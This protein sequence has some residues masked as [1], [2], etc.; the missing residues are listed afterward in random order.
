MVTKEEAINEIPTF[1][2][3][4]KVMCVGCNANDWY[5]PTYC[6]VLEKASRI[7]FEII[8]EKFAEHDGDLFKITRY[9]KETKKGGKRI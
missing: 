2:I 5:C 1:E 3:F 9:I 6:D 4:A 8:Q 7:P